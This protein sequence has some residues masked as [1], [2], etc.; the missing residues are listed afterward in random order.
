MPALTREAFVSIC[1]QAILRTR[2]TITIQNQESGYI[3]FHREIK[4]NNY[5]SNNVRNPLS[6]SNEHAY[7]YRHDLI[8]YVGLGNCHELADF[9]LVEIG[10]EIDNCGS[11]ARMRIVESS[12]F[13]HVYLEIQ[14]HLDG[15]NDFSLWEVDAW[16][17]RII[18]ISTRPDGSIKNHKYLEYGYSAQFQN[19]IYTDEIDYQK[20]YTFFSIPKPKPGKPNKP[21][22]PE[23]EVL[24]KHKN[25]YSDY[26]VE[27]A[28]EAGK[29][30]SSEELN[31]LQQVSYWQ[32]T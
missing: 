20:K 5:F 6:Q 13:D 17:P 7:M 16:D 28:E 14:I 25:L 9:L 2:N 12:K 21:S 23:R 1:K 29:L 11:C 32:F 3:K 10:K 4:E 27:T 8:Q 18:D 30:N 24:T 26:T 19:S 31:Y 15:E 22:T